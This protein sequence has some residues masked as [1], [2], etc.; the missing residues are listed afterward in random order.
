MR[1]H[2]SVA[3]MAVPL[4]FLLFPSADASAYVRRTTDTGR[5]VY[6]PGSCAWVTPDTDVP[7][8][9]TL[10]VAMAAVNR[11]VTNWQS[12]TSSGANACSYIK[13]TVDPPRLK[14]FTNLNQ[15]IAA[16]N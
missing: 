2:L 12:A 3:A 14:S 8:E 6:W 9:L 5:P 1:R 10:D 15:M 16:P 11:A 13:I 7:P 4:A